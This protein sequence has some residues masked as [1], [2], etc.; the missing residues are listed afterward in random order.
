MKK[1]W[2]ASTLMASLAVTATGA[3][4]ASPDLTMHAVTEAQ[5]VKK[6]FTAPQS[7]SQQTQGIEYTKE[8]SYLDDGSVNAVVETWV[9]L[10]TQDKRIDMPAKES[11]GTIHPTSAYLTE[12]GTKW[13]EVTRDKSGKAVSGKFV[14][15]SA[16]D[17]L[18]VD[19]WKSFAEVQAQFAQKGW[20]NEGVLETK[21]GKKLVKLSGKDMLEEDR[22][23]AGSKVVIH[24]YATLDKDLGLPVKLEAY[25]EFNGKQEKQYSVAYE[26]NYVNDKDVFNTSGIPMKEYT[27]LQWIHGVDVEK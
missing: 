8:I 14:K 1:I 11:D 12:K 21:D 15:L 17:A 6:G 4:A 16:E 3:F 27:Q 5:P 26:H 23:P 20:K 2:I 18:S 22:Q 25:A 13:V 19:T 9:D 24:E 10:V 7:A